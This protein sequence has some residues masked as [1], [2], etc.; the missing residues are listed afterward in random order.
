MASPPSVKPPRTTLDNQLSFK[1][2][3]TLTDVLKSLFKWSALVIIAYL[4]A[5][6]VKELAG[7]STFAEFAVRVLGNVT[8]SRSIITLVAGGGWAFG[9]AQRSLRRRNIERTVP[10]KNDL[11]KIIDKNRT[12]SNLTGRGTTPTPKRRS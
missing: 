7:K 1:K 10:A 4:G 6:T 11:E 8:M 9:L 5:N 2:L 12:S 3:D